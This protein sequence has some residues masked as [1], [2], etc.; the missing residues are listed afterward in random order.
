MRILQVSPYYPPHIGG[1]EFHV[2]SLSQR[3]VEAGHDVVVYTSNVPNSRKYEVVG[4]VKIYRFNCPLAPLNNPIM[5]G[6]FLKLIRSSNFDVIHS[7]GHFHVPSSQVAF[8]NIFMRRPFVLTSHGA[9]LGYRGWKRAIE[10]IFNVTVGK[11]TLQAA[12]KVIA[13]TPTQANILQTLGA[14]PSQLVT[15][16]IWVDLNQINL[17]ADAQKFRSRYGLG[18]RKILL[19]VGRLL[20]IKGL[21]YL[22]E[23]A[24]YTKTRPKIVIIGDEAP[25]YPGSK[26]ELQEQTRALGLDEDILFLGSFSRNDLADAYVAADLF[27]LPS[28]AEGLPMVLLEA[29]SYGKC[30]IAT[31]VLGNVDVLRAGWNG[32]LVEPKNP[33]E[34]AEGIDHALTDDKMRERIGAQ[35]RKD[36]ELN[37]TPATILSRILNVYDEVR[38]I[39]RARHSSSH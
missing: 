16:P 10:V 23:A 1:I 4:G 5:P 19:F 17:S 37:Y 6:L 28:L 21:K 9:V 20:P 36:I 24:R 22:I 30:V 8:C 29:M 13:L 39:S 31:R 18:D 27:V 25:G 14:E 32:I 35:A 38:D 33:Q 11:R 15:I 26:Q 3:L 7:H 2:E 34:L 12:D